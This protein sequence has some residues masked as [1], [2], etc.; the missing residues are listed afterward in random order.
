MLLLGVHLL[1]WLWCALSIGNGPIL[2]RYYRAC[3]LIVA[4][5][6]GSP[7][8]EPRPSGGVSLELPSICQGPPLQGTGVP[9]GTQHQDHGV[10]HQVRV[11][12]VCGVHCV[13]MY[14]YMFVCGKE[15]V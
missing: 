9:H 10:P 3:P 11:R 1:C 8:T 13:F 4:P 7:D 12:C 6:P 5:P 15:C 14:V 2:V